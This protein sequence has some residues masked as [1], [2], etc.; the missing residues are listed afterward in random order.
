MVGEQV[1]VNSKGLF[2]KNPE[3]VEYMQARFKVAEEL[4]KINTDLAVE[5]ALEHLMQMQ[6]L[7]RGDNQGLRWIIPAL[8]IR[9]RRDQE[10]YDYMKWWAT[11]GDYDF[12]NTS[13]PFLEKKDQD[14]YEGVDDIV[15]K[16]LLNHLVALTLL[17]IRLLLDLQILKRAKAEAGADFPVE[18]LSANLKKHAMSSATHTD[19]DFVAQDPSPLIAQLEKQIRQLYAQVPQWNK[20]FW[21]GLLSP[22]QH[23]DERPGFYTFGSEG[24]M[25]YALQ[26]NYNSWAETPGA[27]E[28]IRELVRNKVD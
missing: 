9:L 24:E 2:W 12:D 8:M 18:R 7:A 28:V 25:Q 13:L 17:K 21:P 19:A 10:A 22:G 3:T 1:F 14:V 4:M 6:V 5:E 11:K 26:Y 20:H 15:G 16:M 27:I 23:L